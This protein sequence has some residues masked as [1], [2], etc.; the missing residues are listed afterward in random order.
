MIDEALLARIKAGNLNSLEFGPM[1]ESL[2][3]ALP[4]LETRDC[5]DLEPVGSIFSEM[6]FHGDRLLLVQHENGKH[7]VVMKPVVER[8]GLDW[9]GQLQRIKRSEIFSEGV[10]IT[11]TPSAG[12]DQETIA[13]DAEMFHGWLCT[14]DTSRV[15]PEIKPALLTYQ[16]EANRALHD[17]FTKGYAVNERLTNARLQR[18][19]FNPNK[20]FRGQTDDFAEVAW[21]ILARICDKLD[22]RERIS[23][24]GE[25]LPMVAHVYGHPTQPDPVIQDRLIHR[26]LRTGA[27]ITTKE[28]NC[29]TL[30]TNAATSIARLRHRGVPIVK[31]TTRAGEVSRFALAS[32][33]TP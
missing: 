25:V 19:A 14:I 17:Y 1:T 6:D 16:R 27:V 18:I 26:V 24:M 32:S 7:Y 11:T 8:F 21:V 9:R 2:L 13:L 5:T 31:V 30:S 15:N 28:L 33:P 23:F 12:G 29:L 22:A 3:P 10:V 20:P 4:P